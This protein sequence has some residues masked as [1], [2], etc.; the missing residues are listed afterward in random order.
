M[1]GTGQPLRNLL[2]ST[3][4]LVAAFVLACLSSGCGR[5]QHADPTTHDSYKVTLTVEPSPAVMGPGELAVTL[6]DQGGQPVDGA[7][8]EVEANMSHAGMVP[9]LAGTATSAAGV[10]RVPLAWSMAGDWYVDLTFTLPDGQHVARRYPV[11]V[12]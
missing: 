11:Q 12:R 3:P 6:Q 7:R 2:K 1:R 9:V 4:V 10:Y 8:L 5:A